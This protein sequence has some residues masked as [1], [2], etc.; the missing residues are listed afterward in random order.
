MYRLCL[1][2][3]IFMD[4]K[5]AFNFKTYYSKYSKTKGQKHEVNHLMRMT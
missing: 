1:P 5:N 2:N 3:K 4:I